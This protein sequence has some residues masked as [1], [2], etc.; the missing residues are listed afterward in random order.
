MK[1]Q[2]GKLYSGDHCFMLYPS[3]AAAWATMLSTG[4]ADNP[5]S[6]MFL[7]IRARSRAQQ[8]S[9]RLKVKIYS[10][11]ANDTKESMKSCIDYQ[12]KLLC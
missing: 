7:Q 1:F 8:L 9:K 6:K 12:K 2:V 11:D 4:G 5:D 10:N 3:A